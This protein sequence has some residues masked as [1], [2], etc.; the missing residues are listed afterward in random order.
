MRI[1]YHPY[2][3]QDVA[4]AMRRYKHFAAERNHPAAAAWP[5][6]CLPTSSIPVKS[7]L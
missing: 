1:E 5:G 6:C 7:R 2:V 4:E 3:R